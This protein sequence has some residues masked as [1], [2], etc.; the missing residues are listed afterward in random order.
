MTQLPKL[1]DLTGRVAIVTGGIGLLGK[2]F[3]HTLAE[4]GA[5]ITIADL[6]GEAAV[7]LAVSLT[8]SGWC[9]QGQTVDVTSS[10]SVQSMV[11]ATLDAYGR[12]D[13]LVNS[14]ALDPK[15][16]SQSQETHSGS[17]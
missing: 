9:A 17:S 6:D 4:A 7:E 11:T 15:F 8:Q 13:I 16:D 10:E 3:C 2:E 14:A 12:L 1:F 5:A